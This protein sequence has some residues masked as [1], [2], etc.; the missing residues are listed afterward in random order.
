MFSRQ[1]AEEKKRKR[2]EL[3]KGKRK[4]KGEGKRG[5][6]YWAVVYAYKATNIFAPSVHKAALVI[7]ICDRCAGTQIFWKIRKHRYK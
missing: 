6:D 5:K 2:E 3:K 4:K 1:K 7:N